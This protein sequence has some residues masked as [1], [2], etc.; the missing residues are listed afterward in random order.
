MYNKKII[1][2]G[3]SKLGKIALEYYGIEN[4]AYFADNDLSKK[5]NKINGIEIID[6]ETLK[7]IYKDFN[8]IIA[9][10]YKKEIEKQLVDNGIYEHF[11]F[12]IECNNYHHKETFKDSFEKELNDEIDIK[13]L[14]IG[15]LLKSFDNDLSIKNAVFSGGASGI[16]DYLLIR[17]V[18][19]KYNLKRYLEIGSFIG[20]SIDCIYDLCDEFL[21]ISLPDDYV[22]SVKFFEERGLENFSGYFLR[23]KK[24]LRRIIG[25]SM[26]LDFNSINYKPDI[27]YIDGSHTYKGVYSDLTNIIKITD[28]NEGFIILH[29]MKNGFLRKSK[30]LL[31][32]AYGALGEKYSKNFF[33]FDESMCGIYVPD[34]YIEDF[35]QFRKKEKNKMYSYDLSIKVNKNII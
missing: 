31:S 35:I 28:M 19:K 30:E 7:K 34:K 24:K 4:I 29:D 18:I 16:L 27:S 12:N 20:E 9:S 2:F 10:M 26:K 33:C 23:D 8:I 5:G 22:S 3:A 25:D 15:C 6:F 21:S 11:S 32:A 14:N 13:E 17:S 1:I